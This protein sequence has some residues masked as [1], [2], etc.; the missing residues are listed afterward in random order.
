MSIQLKAQGNHL[1]FSRVL[2]SLDFKFFS[3]SQQGCWTPL[4]FPTILPLPQTISWE[5]S[6]TWAH[7][8]PNGHC[9]LLLVTQCAK[10]S[11]LPFVILHSF[12]RWKDISDSFYPVMAQSG[13]SLFS[14][15]VGP[16]RRGFFLEYPSDRRKIRVRVIGGWKR[17]MKKK[18][19]QNI[20]YIQK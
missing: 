17:K 15:K 7:W 4:R 14:F 5:I 16:V 1:H 19:T 18:K 10:P 13:S 6:G 12:S 11:I 9:L 3:F 2:S 20:K 8:V